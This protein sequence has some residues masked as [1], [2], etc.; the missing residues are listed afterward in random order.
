[1][2][3]AVCK[4][5]TMRVGTV[6]PCALDT[7]EPTE[8]V[9]HMRDAHKRRPITADPIINRTRVGWRTPKRRPFEPDEFAVGSWVTWRDSTGEHT[10]QVW[11][12]RGPRS[13]WVADGTTYHDVH[14]AQLVD[15]DAERGAA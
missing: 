1:M 15:V 8:L 6:V 2:F 11:A 9:A 4:T 14:E 13:R 3:H 5:G 7:D 10:G 12:Q